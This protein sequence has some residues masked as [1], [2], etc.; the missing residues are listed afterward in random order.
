MSHE[1]NSVAPWRRPRNI[2]FPIRFGPASSALS[3]AILNL[4]RLYQMPIHGEDFLDY[5]RQLYTIAIIYAQNIHPRVLSLAAKYKDIS[6]TSLDAVVFLSPA[7][8]KEVVQGCRQA[9]EF[10]RVLDRV[11]EHVALEFKMFANALA[12]ACKD[13]PQKLIK[14]HAHGALD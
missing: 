12:A 7:L 1:Q 10:A 6:R 9:D 8:L 4:L 11:C 14:P 5:H 3:L 13:A 2:A